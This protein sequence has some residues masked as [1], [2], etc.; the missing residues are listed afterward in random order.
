MGTKQKMTDGRNIF[1]NRYHDTSKA[2]RGFIQL[3]LAW[4]GSVFKLIW[5]DLLLFLV[6]YSILGVLYR[7]VFIYDEKQKQFFELMCIYASRFSTKIP[8]TFMTGFYV[9]NVVSR[10]WD[11]FVSLPWPDRLAYKIAAYIPGK[12]DYSRTL[13]RTVMRYINLSTLLVFRLVS[14]KVKS[15]FPGYTSIV[16]AGLMLPNEAILLAEIDSR[17]PHETTWAPILWATSLLERERTSGRMKMDPPIF[18]SL[19]TSF[20]YLE[21]CNRRIF[22]HGWVNFP[23]A[24]TQVASLTVYAYLF[25]N[26]FGHQYLEPSGAGTDTQIFSQ[27]NI[28]I[29]LQGPFQFHTPAVFVPYFTIIEFIGYLGWI[30]VAETLLNPWGDDDED[31]QINYLI[32]R[33]LQTSYFI[34]DEAVC[35]LG[36]PPD[37]FLSNHKPVPPQL[38]YKDTKKAKKKKNLTKMRVTK[39]YS[40]LHPVIQLRNHFERFSNKNGSVIRNVSLKPIDE[41]ALENNQMEEKVIFMSESDIDFEAST[42]PT[43]RCQSVE[44]GSSSCIELPL[45]VHIPNQQNSPV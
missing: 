8:V 21:N 23:L 30:K 5:A 29:S 40:V 6:F 24:Y 22:S 13:R 33:N 11:Q 38:P 45:E 14:T 34:V 35:E 44:T 25:S 43:T 7:N 2:G 41:D 18:A 10:Y 12:D 27:F 19:I 15:R 20:D 26:L 28:T 9:A 36:L 4:Q 32:D 3:M 39:K 17:T 1:A 42:M 31:F 37:P 16:E